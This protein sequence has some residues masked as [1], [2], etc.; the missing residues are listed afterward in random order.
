[1]FGDFMDPDA[2]KSERLYK[3]IRDIDELY[4]VVALAIKEYNNI[5]KNPMDLVIFRYLLEHLV[6]VSRI[7]RSPGGHGLL[8]GVG[9]SGRQSLT[10]LAAS[11]GGYQLFQPEISNKY[12]KRVITVSQA[13]NGNTQ[14]MAF[15]FQFRSW[16]MAGGFKEGHEEFRRLCPWHRLIAPRCSLWTP[17]HFCGDPRRWRLWTLNAWALMS[18][19]MCL[20][21]FSW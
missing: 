16:A 5:N 11:M 6:R 9:G 4:R 20:Q 17:V 14:S 21:Q 18:S 12:G 8:V 15:F 13:G 3:E 2:D 10:R 1:M 19:W 7:L